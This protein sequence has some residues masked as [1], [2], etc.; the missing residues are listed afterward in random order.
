MPVTINLAENVIFTNKGMF[1][2]L[3]KFIFCPMQLI[4]HI[5][6]AGCIKYINRNLYIQKSKECYITYTYIRNVFLIVLFSEIYLKI[7]VGSSGI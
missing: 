4:S 5:C 6:Q 1:F 7:K 2:L 3:I